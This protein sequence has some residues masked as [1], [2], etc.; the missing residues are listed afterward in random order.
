FA[1]NEQRLDRASLVAWA[2][3]RFESPVQMDELSNK[4]REE[5]RALLVGHSKRFQQKSKAA[6]AEAKSKVDKLFGKSDDE[7]TAGRV[8]GENGSVDSRAAW[9]NDSYKVELSREQ[10]SELS[11]AEL[12]RTILDAVEERYRPEMRRMERSLL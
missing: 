8:A 6:L 11:R 12:R 4:Q 2:S 7:A 3:E 10:I 1:P 5:I 9:L